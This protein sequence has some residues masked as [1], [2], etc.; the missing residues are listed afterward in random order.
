MNRK[1]LVLTDGNVQ[2]LQFADDLDIPLEDRFQ[3]SQRKFRIL[4][5]FLL[6]QGFELPGAFSD[7][8]AMADNEG[9]EL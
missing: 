1:P 2:Q 5:L 3:Y 6:M 8:L 4:L 7:D 9:V